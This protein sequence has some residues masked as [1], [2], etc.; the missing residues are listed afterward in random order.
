MADNILTLSVILM[1]PDFAASARILSSH[2]R[3]QIGFLVCVCSS[4]GKTSNIEL[5]R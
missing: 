1:A 2:L 4:R 3:L 5:R